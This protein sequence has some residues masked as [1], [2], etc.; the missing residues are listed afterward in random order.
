MSCTAFPAI[1]IYTK[2]TNT[3]IQADAIRDDGT[4]YNP[5]EI[6]GIRILYYGPRNDPTLY[7]PLTASFTTGNTFV[8]IVS[9]TLPQEGFWGFQ[10]EYTIATSGE[11][12]HTR[13]FYE[14]VGFTIPELV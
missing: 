1:K 4:A 9:G 7:T 3:A 13:I 14:Y 5:S 12:V 11:V 8:G 2:D 10:F 6:S